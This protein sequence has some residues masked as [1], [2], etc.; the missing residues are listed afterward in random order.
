MQIVHG[1][2]AH[3]IMASFGW[4]KRN[5][6]HFTQSLLSHARARTHSS[7]TYLLVSINGTFHWFPT[8][9]DSCSNNSIVYRSLTVSGKSAIWN[10]CAV[11]G[12]TH[13]PTEKKKVPEEVAHLRFHWIVR[14]RNVNRHRSDKRW[15]DSDVDGIQWGGMQKREEAG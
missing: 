15:I 8:K 4:H 9:R 1:R 2:A 11:G 7:S 5:L 12:K 13:R 10:T 14:V 6:E 3:N